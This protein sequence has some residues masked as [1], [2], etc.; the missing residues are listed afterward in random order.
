MRA[1]SIMA[2][3]LAMVAAFTGCQGD[4]AAVAAPPRATDSPPNPS[5]R[6]LIAVP[7]ETDIAPLKRELERAVPRTLWT[8]NQRERRCIKP[9]RV[10]VFGESVNVTPPIACTIVGQVTRGALRL[11]G[12][13]QDI[14]IDM[15]ITATVKAQDADRVFKGETATA[16]AMAHARIRVDVRPDWQLNGKAR[17][18]YGWT[19]EPSIDFLGRRITFTRQADNALAPVVRAIERQINAEF[20]R[21]DLRGQAGDIWRQAFA[22]LELNRERPPVWLRVT[23]QRLLYGGYRLNG[24]RLT[25]DL[26]MEAMAETF[27]SGKP[28]ANAATPLPNLVRENP[29]PHFDVRVPVIADYAELEPVVLRALVKRSQ[30][31]FDI[32]AIGAVDVK[33]GAVTAYGTTG[34]RVAVGIDVAAMARARQGKPTRGKIWLTATPVTT[35]GSAVVRFADVQVTGDTDAVSGD[36]L[37]ALAR[38]DNFAPLIAEALTQNLTKDLTELEGKIRKVT[39]ER[40]EGAFFIRTQID[41]FETGQITA[42]GTGLFMPVRLI[43]RADVVYQPKP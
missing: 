19:R 43:G 8:I 25:V 30:R 9:K 5:Q 28:A 29:A 37:L 34:N 3:A 21:I 26:G 15:P 41:R 22:V 36:L 10:K 4:S 35:A 32:P 16:S 24:Q 13:G 40:R 12:E 11:R 23:P 31:P 27:V 18:S 33:F 17:I 42:Y 14:V 2:A 20:A 6:S 38:R 1:A 7:I 39:A